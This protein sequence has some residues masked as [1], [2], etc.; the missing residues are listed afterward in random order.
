MK[1]SVP[2]KGSGNYFFQSPI[3][4]V[5]GRGG[6]VPEAIFHLTRQLIDGCRDHLAPFLQN[7]IPKRA[8][9]PVC[10]W[11]G[12][13]HFSGTTFFS[14]GSESGGKLLKVFSQGRDI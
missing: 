8:S 10:I 2:K 7:S 14:L 4:H 6:A 11:A 12:V 5:R 1:I 13:W 9:A 3:N